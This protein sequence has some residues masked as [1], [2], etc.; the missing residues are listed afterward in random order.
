MLHVLCCATLDVL[1]PAHL[2]AMTGAEPPVPSAMRAI[3]I[4]PDFVALLWSHVVQ[5]GD[6]AVTH[7]RLLLN[8]TGAGHG[9]MLSAAK[10]SKTIVSF[11]SSPPSGGGLVCG[12]LLPSTEYLVMV[13]ACGSGGCSGFHSLTLWTAPY[14]PLNFTVNVITSSPSITISLAWLA[15]CAETL[16][17]AAAYPDA[18]GNPVPACPSPITSSLDVR[19]LVSH[20][21]L[22]TSES[23]GWTLEVSSDGSGASRAITLS[24][25]VLESGTQPLELGADYQARLVAVYQ[26]MRSE[27]IFLTSKVTSSPLSVENFGVADDIHDGILEDSLTMKWRPPGASAVSYYKLS[28]A[29]VVS[30]IVLPYLADGG[31]LGNS[32]SGVIE[33]DVRLYNEMVNGSGFNYV[34]VTGLDTHTLYSF[35]IQARNF[36]SNGYEG[37]LGCSSNTDVSQSITCITAS[38]VQAPASVQHLH[39]KSATASLVEVEWLP[40]PGLE[41]SFRDSLVFRLSRSVVAGQVTGP[42]TVLASSLSVSQLTGSNPRTVSYRDESA[43]QD[44]NYRYRVQARNRNSLGFEEGSSVMAALLTSTCASSDVACT[45]SNVRAVAFT[46]RA[47]SSGVG[48]VVEWDPP[49]GLFAGSV[50]AQFYYRI[51]ASFDPQTNWGAAND[52]SASAPVDI[53]EDV[54]DLPPGTNRALLVNGVGFAADKDTDFAFLIQARNLNCDVSVEATCTSQYSADSDWNALTYFGTTQGPVLSTQAR[55]QPPPL[56]NIAVKITTMSSVTLSWSPTP[57]PLEV[58]EF[59]AKCRVSGDGMA[60]WTHPNTIT[61]RSSGTQALAG[62]ITIPNLEEN[63]LYD[64]IVFSRNRQVDAWEGHGS[65]VISSRPL[66]PPSAVLNL[67]V[68]EINSTT[69]G[70]GFTR[71]QEAYSLTG[72]LVS[73]M[74]TPHVPVSATPNENQTVVAS[75]PTTSLGFEQVFAYVAGLEIGQVYYLAVQAVNPGGGGGA[76]RITVRPFGP[77]S[78]PEKVQVT[79]ANSKATLVTWKAPLNLGL[80]AGLEVK[81]YEVVALLPPGAVWGALASYTVPVGTTYVAA[82]GGTTISHALDNTTIDVMEGLELSYGVYALVQQHMS[83]GGGVVRGAVSVASVLVGRIPSWADETPP[84]AFVIFAWI[85]Q[86]VAV[87]IQAFDADMVPGGGGMRF[88]LL[89]AAPPETAQGILSSGILTEGAVIHEY[90][91]HTA[92]SQ[93]IF[94]GSRQLSGSKYKVCVRGIDASNLTTDARC[95]SVQIPRPTPDFV[96]P[97]NNSSYATAVGCHLIVPLVAQDR[98][99]F[100]L[101]PSVVARNGYGVTIQP[102]YTFTASRYHEI[103]SVGLPPGALLST[104]GGGLV[105]SEAQPFLTNLRNAS[106]QAAHTS[107][108]DSRSKNPTSANLEWIARKGQESFKYRICVVAIDL[109]KAFSSVGEVGAGEGD[110]GGQVF[111]LNVD[112]QRCRY[113]PRQQDSLQTVAKSWHGAWLEVWSGNHI[114]DSP[115]SLLFDTSPPLQNPA[116]PSS[117]AST[118]AGPQIAGE[119]SKLQ[120]SFN[121]IE[122]GVM[123]AVDEHDDLWHLALRY[124]VE[125]SDVLFWNPDLADGKAKEDQYALVPHQELC[126]LPPTCIYSA[127]VTHQAWD[128]AISASIDTA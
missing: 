4:G 63:T 125:L 16:E 36:N 114:Y 43:V 122:V 56:S 41:A 33:F 35:R 88:E 6:V 13:G 59:M 112:V 94:K 8:A 3:N 89:G 17:A 69:V 119:A 103:K 60:G 97:P 61:A 32:Q 44:V 84:D 49:P 77:A 116:P 123:Y 67:H 65:A 72:Y 12:G 51:R 110:G 47:G 2:A 107:S 22:V 91:N 95:Y 21:K 64:F 40:P 124:G 108:P 15:P 104:Q 85:G 52:Q 37:G 118:Q 38:P 30:S 121:P 62:T 115:D 98:T 24:N 14:S 82:S 7:F 71:P 46:E 86:T 102:L 128:P 73:R 117:R 78:G 19:Y 111:C 5:P 93:L 54:S 74:S 70:L 27:P 79:M 1:Q 25:L 50:P 45:V 23:T 76:A 53:G 120:N 105:N 92:T 48:V 87:Q 39:V 10:R 68:V 113:C 58:P 26:G 11:G 99:S 18:N 20:R 81:G 75:V 109:S 55:L 42:E 83:L 34:A 66:R 29:K 100:N 96:T 80:A 101:D 90:L 28:W 126:L 31:G 57:S 127:R 106:S 9:S